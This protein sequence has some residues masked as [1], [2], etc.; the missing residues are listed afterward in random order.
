MKQQETQALLS[1][2]LRQWVALHRH[3]DPHRLALQQHKVDF[4]AALAV[5]QVALLQKA[6]AKLPR[7]AAA[8]CILTQRAYEQST[9][10]VLASQKPWGKGAMA[11][12]LTCGLG[13]D[14]YQIASH[15]DSLIS[16]E[17]DPELAAIVRFNAELL[18][19]TG[20]TIE[21]QTAEA[22]LAAYSG[23]PFDLI[24]ADPDRRDG[25]GKR[26]FGL[27]ECQPNVLELLPLLRRH[28]KRILIKGSPMLDL[29]AIQHQF[30]EGVFV[31]VLSE[32]NECKEV[33]IEPYPPSA[34]T[35]AIFV[36]KGSTGKMESTLHSAF[37]PSWDAKDAPSHILECDVAL[38]VAGLSDAYMRQA[39]IR[40]GMLSPESYWYNLEDAPSFLGHRY[41][42]LADWPL[43]PQAIKAALKSRGI[44]KVQY[45]KRDF[46]LPLEQVRKQIGLP[47][48]GELFLL[49]TRYGEKGRW[50]FL[51]ERLV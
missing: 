4:P 10:E 32:A 18:E 19:I 34:G 47:E 37:H 13:C 38:Y 50:A 12:D 14:S 45:S 33:L 24:Y 48:G 6:A 42:I 51:A 16:L 7:M 23:P 31:W 2:A 30:P 49:L 20:M 41:K 46:D 17:P 27:A 29:K 8:Q 35:G 22:F 1:A 39:E 44:Q 43:K 15:Y 11:L 36:R 3:E 25:S 26:V 9:S 40:G 28:G 21:N 5:G